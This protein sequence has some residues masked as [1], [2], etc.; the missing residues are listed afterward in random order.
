MSIGRN[1]F[2]R[3]MRSSQRH[4]NTLCYLA[5]VME[6]IFC[7]LNDVQNGL[8]NPSLSHQENQKYSSIASIDLFGL[9]FLKTSQHNYIASI[10]LFGLVLL[11]NIQHNYNASIDLFGLVFPK[12]SNKSS[13]NFNYATLLTVT[14]AKHNTDRSRANV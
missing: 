8:L 1:F 12:I 4:I 6:T 7:I 14:K 11:K 5:N 13:V 3:P 2:K 9:V 10:D